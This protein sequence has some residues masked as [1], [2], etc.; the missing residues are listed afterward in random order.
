MNAAARTRQRQM[1]LMNAMLKLHM[2]AAA[3]P[4]G[5]GGN[6]GNTRKK[7]SAPRRNY[8]LGR[9]WRNKYKR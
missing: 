2:L 1:A 3:M 7:K 6:G 5:N 8:S 9:A 4:K